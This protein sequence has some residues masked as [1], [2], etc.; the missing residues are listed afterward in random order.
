[1]G[2]SPAKVL[3]VCLF[4]LLSLLISLDFHA[5]GDPD[6]WTSGRKL[7]ERQPKTGPPSPIKNQG[8]S[9]YWSPGGVG[10]RPRPAPDHPGSSAV[11]TPP[12][13]T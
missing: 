7:G 8:R 2:S 13:Q 10:D 11:P 6:E 5:S 12:I 9:S 1:M 3:A 4:L